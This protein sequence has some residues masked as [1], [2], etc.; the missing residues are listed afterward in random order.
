MLI[1]S[2][3]LFLKYSFGVS[4]GYLPEK[5]PS[6]GYG[7]KHFGIHAF[8]AS[9]TKDNGY[10]PKL[11]SILFNLAVELKNECDCHIAFINLSGGVGVD[12]RLD[13][14]KN[15]IEIIGD[16]VR[17]AYEE[18]LTPNG[19]DDV[20]IFTELGRFML[21]PYG[22]LVAKAIH[23]KHIYKEY[24]DLDACAANLMNASKDRY[25]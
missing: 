25:W 15:D 16:G 22:H 7:V 11:A 18:I 17:K 24:I 4:I 13:E 19:M 23:E 14:P 20:K 2:S 9:N 21:A 10:Y 5:Q 1:F 12:Y 8:L 3:N 6:Q